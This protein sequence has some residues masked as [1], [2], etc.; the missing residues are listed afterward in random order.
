MSTSAIVYMNALP[1]T[2][3]N[4]ARHIYLPDGSQH[5]LDSHD[6]SLFCAPASAG[7]VIVMEYAV[8]EDPSEQQVARFAAKEHA[9]SAERQRREESAAEMTQPIHKVPAPE[10]VNVNPSMG[11]VAPIVPVQ[12]VPQR[13]PFPVVQELR[14]SRVAV[15][16]GE[17]DV[18]KSSEVPGDVT[19]EMVVPDFSPSPK[20]G[21]PESAESSASS[22]GKKSGRTPKTRGQGRAAG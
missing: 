14:T 17:M 22:T 16:P 10:M 2:I 13:A 21:T 5:L 12:P 9:E 18:K 8:N 1:I 3:Q 15:P 7:V 19:G 4:V 20:E 11:T 6:R